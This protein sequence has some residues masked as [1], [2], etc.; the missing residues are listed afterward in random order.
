MAHNVYVC[1]VWGGGGGRMCTL[2]GAEC[3]HYAHYEYFDRGSLG[4]C[5]KKNEMVKSR[6]HAQ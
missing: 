6:G 1:V 4:I 3:V 5:E 2:C